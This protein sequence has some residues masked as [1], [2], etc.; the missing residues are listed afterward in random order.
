MFKK[1]GKGHMKP[2]CINE[3]CSNFL[4]EEKRGYR[5]TAKKEEDASAGAED[6]K[7]PKTKSA[8]KTAKTASKTASKSKTKTMSK[9]QAEEST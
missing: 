3:A 6:E 7:T 1:S 2:F 4:P 9:K 8:G 5:K